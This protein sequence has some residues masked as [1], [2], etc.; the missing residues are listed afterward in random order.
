MFSQVFLATRYCDRKQYALKVI[1]KRRVQR[2]DMFL[3]VLQEKQ[4][5]LM[6]DH[7]S[8]VKLYWT[9]KDLLCVYMMMELGEGGE[10]WEL[11]DQSENRKLSLGMTR[12]YA[13]ELV[14]VLEYIHSKQVCHRDFKP[15]N[16]LLT[17]TGHLKVTDFGTS[18]I[19]TS[20]DEEKGDTTE[21]EPA[22]KT[23]TKGSQRGVPPGKK[24]KRKN[25]FVGTPE[26]MAP[27]II[28]NYKGKGTISD[29]WSLGILIFQLL[30]GKVP[31][32]GGS[33]YLTMKKVD[34]RS[35]PWPPDLDPDAR[36][37]IENLLQA[38]PTLRLG[39]VERG[40]FPTLRRHPF[41]RDIDFRTVHLTPVPG[42]PPVL[43]PK[44]RKPAE[45]ALLVEAED[46]EDSEPEPEP[47]LDIPEESFVEQLS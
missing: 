30:V 21:P 27:E 32:H 18:K 28:H 44:P 25:S 17:A 42:Y 37:L 23:A 40:G 4:V 38:E 9:F 47:E 43:V 8:I 45:A 35:I 26:Y 16:I 41:F 36:D 11:W 14:N 20:S 19:L 46:F 31:F 29:L 2:N 33:A 12:H 10:L 34:K 13:A 39:S 3:Y 7:P 22:D 5:M 6:L 24:S 1:E 15:E